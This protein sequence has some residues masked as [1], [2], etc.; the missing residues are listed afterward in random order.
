[1]TATDRRA[2]LQRT[3]ATGSSLFATT[4]LPHGAFATDTRATA[5]TL[6]DGT[7][8]SERTPASSSRSPATEPAFAA[9]WQNRDGS[10]WGVSLVCPDSGD[11]RSWPLGARGHD[12]LFS[13]DGRRLLV[14]ARRPGRFLSIIDLHAR[15]DDR[16]QLT[17]DAADERHFYGHGCFS[18]DGRWLFATE[19]DYDNARGVIGV[20]DAHNDWQ[21]VREFPSHG[22]GPHD[23]ALAGDGHT[24]LVANGGIETHPDHRREKLNLADM[25]SMLTLVDAR[26]GKLIRQYPLPDELQRLSLRHLAMTADGHTVFGCQFEGDT[27]F[28]VPLIGCLE[29]NGAFTL[30]QDSADLAPRMNGYVSSVAAAG[31]GNHVAATSS[32]GGIV[33]IWDATSGK[34]V[35]MRHI[36]DVSGVDRWHDGWLTSDGNGG[37]NEIPDK[38][39]MT[40]DTDALKSM[41]QQD[42]RWDNH[43]V[44]ML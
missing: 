19:N 37:M 32:R 15:D 3:L 13:P 33:G 1:M 24:L 44:S 18:A 6:A 26:D 27:T 36:T 2:F 39:G 4:L 17:I 8:A 42:R 5:G 43:L 28:E 25:R 16:T 31:T 23:I 21:R 14:F 10:D 30:W 29:R 35:D 11:T 20:Y 12:C 40:I 7:S 38:S 41:Q 9:A 22:V 34:L